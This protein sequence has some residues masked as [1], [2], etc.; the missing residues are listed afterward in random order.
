MG[1]PMGVAMLRWAVILCLAVGAC[2]TKTLDTS[3]KPKG[4]GTYE[5]VGF[6]GLGMRPED[7]KAEATRLSW[8]EEYLADNHLCPS[9]Y[10]IKSREAVEYRVYY[11]VACKP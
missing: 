1:Q 10:E 5:Y 7:P 9:G 8:L 2:A 4:D 11:T 6:A 3:F